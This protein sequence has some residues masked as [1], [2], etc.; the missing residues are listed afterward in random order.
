M[1]TH[2][3]ATTALQGA[4][5]GYYKNARIGL[6]GTSYYDVAL[7]REFTKYGDVFR[8]TSPQEVYHNRLTHVVMCLP[9]KD[10][11]PNFEKL[12]RRATKQVAAMA[13]EAALMGAVSVFISTADV[14]PQEPAGY[15]WKT[16]D[17]PKPFSMYGMVSL[18]AEYFTKQV[19]GYIIRT[20]SVFG[21]GVSSAP[22]L[23]F[24]T[25]KPERSF[26]V[27]PES[28]TPVNDLAYACV[29]P[30]HLDSVWGESETPMITHLVV[31]G[32]ASAKDF[33][34]ALQGPCDVKPWI[35]R[36]RQILLESNVPWV[37]H[38]DSYYNPHL[39]NRE[40]LDKD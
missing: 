15:R 23:A 11:E 30:N 10:S 14:F 12:V 17:M 34:V 29:Y 1:Y 8:I 6:F 37:G 18:Y 4:R 25:S 19:G 26:S 2:P 36:E 39:I 7:Q 32:E 20:G 22:A 27:V 24:D 13:L 3:I 40:I 21:V 9:D 38:V 28:W 5:G 35:P 31:H 16:T 33:A